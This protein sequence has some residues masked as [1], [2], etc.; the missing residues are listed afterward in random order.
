MIKKIGAKIAAPP[1]PD[2]MA[3]VATRMA[4]GN[5]NQYK[6]QSNAAKSIESPRV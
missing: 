4:T 6:V 5:M 2:S 1:M 3:E